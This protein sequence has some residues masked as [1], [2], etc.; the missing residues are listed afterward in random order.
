MSVVHVTDSVHAWNVDGSSSDKV[1]ETSW[2]QKWEEAT[3]DFRGLCSFSDCQRPSELGGHLWI[4]H[5]GVHLAPICAPCNRWDNAARM[6]HAHGLH[7]S[8]RPGTK[9]LKLQMTEDMCAARRRISGTG[10]WRGSNKTQRQ[11]A[12]N[13]PKRPIMK[14]KHT[15][16]S[17]ARKHRRCEECGCSLLGT[18]SHHLLCRS[19]YFASE[20]ESDLEPDSHSDSQQ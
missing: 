10:W 20:S 16:S 3:G 15:K 4:K 14:K 7:S 12:Q 13:V 1:L 17:W 8:I 9:L 2:I 18:P 19:C 5:Q 11:S 6:Q